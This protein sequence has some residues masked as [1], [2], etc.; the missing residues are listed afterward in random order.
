MTIN[1]EDLERIP[2]DGENWALFLP[3]NPLDPST[4]DMACT[5][6]RPPT[7]NESIGFIKIFCVKLEQS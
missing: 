2:E 4:K 1:L 5:Y 3:S 7:V 6:E